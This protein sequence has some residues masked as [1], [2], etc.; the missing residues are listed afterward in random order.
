MK[1]IAEWKELQLKVLLNHHQLYAAALGLAKCG[2]G[3]LFLCALLEYG[4]GSPPLP[5]S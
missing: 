2:V 1:W 3:L 5:R 4:E